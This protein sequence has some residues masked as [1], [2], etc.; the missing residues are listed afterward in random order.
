MGIVI[1]TTYQWDLMGF[2][3]DLMGDEWEILSG[4]FHIAI[5]NGHFL[6]G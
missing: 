6:A 5:V 3:S 4:I 2:Y 1:A